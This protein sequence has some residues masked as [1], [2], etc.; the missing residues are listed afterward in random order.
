MLRLIDVAPDDLFAE[1]FRQSSF[2]SLSMGG[3]IAE[4]ARVVASAITA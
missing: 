3:S 4:G 1:L 2:G